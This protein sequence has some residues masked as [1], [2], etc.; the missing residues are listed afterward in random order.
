[1]KKLTPLLA[2]SAACLFLVACSPT[3]DW[4]EVRGEG[5]G[6]MVLLPAKPSAH[7]RAVNLDG[8][9][10]QMTMTGAET[11]DVSFTVAT[12]ELPDAEQARRALQ[13]MKTAMLRNV[14]A[15]ASQDKPVTV[16][17]ATEAAEVTATGG[18]DASGR[19]RLMAARFFVRERRVFQMVVLGRENGV[20]Q[21]AIE[22]FL[23]SFKPL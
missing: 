14:G 23:T 9:Q 16:A 6:Y 2:G 21:E 5:A 13:A 18:A 10:V 12:A 7:T 20:S 11:D 15:S 8:V 19:P 22:T 4:R 17:G 3:Y 1:M